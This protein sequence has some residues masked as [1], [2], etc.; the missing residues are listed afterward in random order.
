ME[1]P[2]AGKCAPRPK[3]KGAGGVGALLTTGVVYS[4]TEGGM[5]FIISLGILQA[6]CQYS[7]FE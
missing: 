7:I 1:R 6:S 3:K 4:G 5:I 2:A